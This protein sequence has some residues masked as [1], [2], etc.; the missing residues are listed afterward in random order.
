[1]HPIT[2][3]HQI[4]LLIQEGGGE[5]GLLVSSQG[6][7]M[8]ISFSQS[9]FFATIFLSGCASGLN[10]HKFEDVKI[11]PNEKAFVLLTDS[12]W[13]TNL[14]LELA[15]HGFKI[16]KFASTQNVRKNMV[17]ESSGGLVEDERLYKEAGARYGI[18]L[19]QKSQM[20]WC[21]FNDNIKANFSLEVS[22]LKTNDVVMVIEKANWTGLCGPFSVRSKYVFE[23]LADELVNN[24]K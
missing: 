3:I 23:E 8:A 6:A 10:V 24:W 20:D 1:M 13:A 18:T 5:G 17:T 21:P 16:K 9:L 15:K 4:A 11:D 12:N 2:R 22:D 14:R 7:T 19:T